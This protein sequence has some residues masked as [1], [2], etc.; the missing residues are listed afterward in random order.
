[1]TRTRVSIGVVRR[2][3]EMLNNDGGWEW[4]DE[5]IKEGKLNGKEKEKGK[6]RGGRKEKQSTE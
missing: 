5:L 6:G 3:E 1:M 2:E 4:V